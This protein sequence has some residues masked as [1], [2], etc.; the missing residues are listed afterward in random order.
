MRC[1]SVEF[2]MYT[3]KCIHSQPMHSCLAACCDEH[4]KKYYPRGLSTIRPSGG[5][6]SKNFWCQVTGSNINTNNTMNKENND[7]DHD[8]Y[9]HNHNHNHRNTI[10]VCVYQ[11]VYMYVNVIYTYICIFI[12]MDS[13]WKFS[14]SFQVNLHWTLRSNDILHFDSHAIPMGKTR[15]SKHCIW[16]IQTAGILGSRIVKTAWDWAISPIPHSF[17]SKV[18]FH[19]LKL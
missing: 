9:F 6:I 11:C 5:F 3:Y 16:S 13:I 15:R 10:A 1:H 18:I 7:N 2:Y 17:W 12:Y 8:D 19:P 4:H 14:P